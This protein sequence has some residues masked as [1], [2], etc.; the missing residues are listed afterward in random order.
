MTHM[1]SWKALSLVL[2]RCKDEAVRVLAGG[3][4]HFPE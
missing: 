1:D 3:K 2:R 4:V